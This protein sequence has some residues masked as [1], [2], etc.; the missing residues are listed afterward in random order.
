MMSNQLTINGLHGLPQ[1]P[2][3]P[4]CGAILLDLVEEFGLQPKR[5]SSTN[6]GEYHSACPFCGEGDDRFMFWPSQNRYWCRRCDKKGDAIQFCRDALKMDYRSACEKVG[7]EPK[8]SSHRLLRVQSK[9]KFVPKVAKLS[10]VLWNEKAKEFVRISH[11]NLLRNPNALKHLLDRKFTLDTIKKF[12]LGWNPSDRNLPFSEWGLPPDEADKE[13]K[14][15]LPKGFVIPTIQEGTVIKLKV[16]RLNYEKDK[17]Q[18]KYVVVSGSMSCLSLYGKI[19]TQSVVVVESEFDAMLIQQAA[20]D[21][22]CCIALGGVA[23]EPDHLTDQLLKGFPQILYCPDF[24]DAGKKSYKFWKST[25][26]QVR[27]WPAPEGK[28]PGDAIKQGIDLRSWII[29]G[30]K[31]V[32]V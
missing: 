2:R 7:V 24:D 5:T 32:S 6:G 21:L 12:S 1:D 8:A 22:C 25:Y 13:K 10:P 9:P 15:W 26:S 17:I 31:R 3:L 16:R 23:N 4:Q 27:C 30:L 20:G 28:S 29:S 14:L 19:E 18:R 11:Q